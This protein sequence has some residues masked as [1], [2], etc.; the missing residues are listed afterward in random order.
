[1]RIIKRYSNRRLYDT[2]ASRTITQFDLARMIREGRRLK[3]VD[4]ATGRD[5][6]VEVL[7]RVMVA[8]TTR[9]GNLN[10]AREF[11]R[12]LI[13]T[14]GNKSMSILRNTVLASM[15]KL[16]TPPLVIGMSRIRDLPSR[17]SS[18]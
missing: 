11:L 5:I 12:D 14:G 3:V 18:L 15:K 8:E 16:G 17:C 10:E 9:H 2:A 6:T 1:M 4:S 7:G 13:V